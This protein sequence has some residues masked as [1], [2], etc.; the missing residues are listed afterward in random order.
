MKIKVFKFGG[1]SVKDADGFRNITD[2][3]LKFKNEG[4]RI[5][6]VVS[7]TGK[8]TNALEKALSEAIENKGQI[9][10]T[11]EEIADNH[12]HIASQLLTK[13]QSAISEIQF[14]INRIKENLQNPL[15]ELYDKL[16]DTVI[17]E[18]ERLSTLI[19]SE[20]FIEKNVDFHLED[21]RNI[22]KTNLSW[23]E[24]E[25]NWKS[26]KE[27]IQRFTENVWTSRP[28]ALFF[29]QGFIGGGPNRESVTLGR[30]GSD[31]SAALLAAA[32]K[33]ESLTI[34]KD[35][36]GVFNADPKI[37]SDAVMFTRL[38]YEN[39]IEL[40]WYGATIIH[41]KTL[42]PLKNEGVPLFVKSFLSPETPGTQIDNKPTSGLVPAL[43]YKKNQILWTINLTDG[44]FVNEKLLAEILKVISEN[45]IKINALQETALELK[46]CMDFDKIR[47]N[48]ALI[49]LS[50]KF[51]ITEKKNIQL[52][53][54]INYSPA[55]MQNILDNQKP[56]MEQ[57]DSRIARF[58][59]N[60]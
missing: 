39:A 8:T 3:I 14:I 32:L 22:I 36:P 35:V 16:Y 43:I 28:G 44:Q 54:I 29:T 45:K 18:G 27:A 49:K 25:V 37:F 6:F 40:A 9:I 23:R 42:F 58:V 60:E 31:Y 13:P 21:A 59:I 53:T 20:Y 41:P 1:A 19:L 52:V 47:S 11:L 30:E 15:P 5:A 26:T 24:G 56:Y 55:L 10:P 38:S 4:K 57:R 2:I 48:N 33:A 12:I 7:A 46:L 17:S 50:K 51:L 34:W